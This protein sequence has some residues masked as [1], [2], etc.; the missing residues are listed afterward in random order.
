MVASK[1]TGLKKCWENH[2]YS[3]VSRSECKKKSQ[4]KCR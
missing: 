4:H 1:E 3:H 2:V